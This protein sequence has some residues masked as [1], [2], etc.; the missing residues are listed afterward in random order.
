MVPSAILPLFISWALYYNNDKNAYVNNRWLSVTA[1]FSHFPKISLCI[2]PQVLCWQIRSKP[3]GCECR[4]IGRCRLYVVRPW[5]R[6]TSKIKPM[7]DT[8]ASATTHDNWFLLPFTLILALQSVCSM[9]FILFFTQAFDRQKVFACIYMFLINI[10]MHHLSRCTE[11][12]QKLS[13]F[14]RGTGV[15]V[16]CCG[17]TRLANPCKYQWTV[18]FLLTTE[19]QSNSGHFC[20]ISCLTMYFFNPFYWPILWF[21]SWFYDC[22]NHWSGWVPERCVVF[23]HV[24]ER[25]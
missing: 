25:A 20:D 19:F 15:F 14:G 24:W 21:H 8:S 13:L 3:I 10:T 17:P 4:G 5:W 11:P 9:V 23:S 1:A 16:V 2:R 6:R 18:L 22:R 12:V 7:Q